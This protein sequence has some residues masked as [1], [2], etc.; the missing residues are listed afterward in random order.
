V[1]TGEGK[2]V[3]LGGFSCLLALLGFDVYCAS[4]STHLSSRDYDAFKELF[5]AFGVEDSVKYS[6]LDGL[7]E[8]IINDDGDVR[9]LSNECIFQGKTSMFRKAEKSNDKK[10]ILLIDEV[11]VFFSPHFY[12]ATYNPIS[13]FCSEETV[14]IMKAIWNENKRGNQ[15]TLVS[16]QKMKE[17]SSLQ[18]KICPEATALLNQHINFMIQ[19]VSKYNDPS[20]EIVNNEKIGYKNQDS[21]SCTTKYRYRTAFAYLYEASRHPAMVPHLDTALALQVPCGMF[22][23]AA[24]PQN[25]FSC[26]MGVTG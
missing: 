15:P 18:G 2:S 5:I 1:G 4:Y 21:V 12:G 16:I 11:D 7:M 6:T 26:I 23:F 10:R 8:S 25:Q 17:Y 22:S 24:I 9:E 19:D 20:Y 13:E 3:L 14:A